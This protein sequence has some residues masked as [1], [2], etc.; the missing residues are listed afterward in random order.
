MDTK[1]VNYRDKRALD[2]F[3]VVLL[4]FPSSVIVLFCAL[5]IMIE[6][7]SNPFFVQHRVG[8]GGQAFKLVKLRTMAPNTA[9]IPSHQIDSRAILGSGKL[10]RATKLDELPQL[11]NVL[12]GE[13]SFVGPR[14]CLPS[15]EEVITE[16]AERGVLRLLPGIT[17]PSQLAGIDMSTPRKLAA[18]DALYSMNQ[19]AVYDILILV[20]T[21]L[22]RGAGDPANQSS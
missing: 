15:Q 19:S 10:L 5:V 1:P 20:R 22:G 6:T 8:L 2:I 11:W 9:S 18:T 14:P 16:R 3:L 4:A 21:L 13:M 7:R 17:G 12:I